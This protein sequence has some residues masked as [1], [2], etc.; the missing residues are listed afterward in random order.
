MGNLVAYTPLR[1]G[2]DLVQSPIAIKEGRALIL[3][4]FELTYG[5]NGYKRIDGYECF[6]GRPLASTAKYFRVPVSI[7]TT[8]VAGDAV[9]LGTVSA[10]VV[11]YVTNELVVCYAND[12]IPSSGNVVV[13]GTNVG[14][15]TG[16]AIKGAI[17]DDNYV[18]RRNAAFDV[19]RGLTQPLN[20]SGAILGVAI[21]GDKVIAVRNEADG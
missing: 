10:L 1:V 14:T 8:P 20:G 13:N 5:R 3:N 4:N 18:T 11:E 9:I 6:D 19:V 12:A 21:Y 15:I 16:A 7:T 2:L 17:D